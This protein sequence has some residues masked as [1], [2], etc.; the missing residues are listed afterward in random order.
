MTTLRNLGPRSASRGF[1]LVEILVGVAIG[2]VGML[3]IF[4]TIAVWDTHTRSTTAGSDSQNTGSLA[5][6][7]LE[8]DVKQA[9]HGFMGFG[10]T[11]VTPPASLGCQVNVADTGARTLPFAPFNMAPVEIVLTPGQPD[12]INVLSGNSPFFVSE[13]KFVGST[14]TSK[15]LERR[16]GF[17]PGDLAIAAVGPVCNLI[18][19][20]DDT[21]ADGRTID[22][23][24]AANYPSFYAAPAAPPR[25]AR[26]NSAALPALTQLGTLYS[27]GPNPIRNQWGVIGGNLTRT[28][29]FSGGPA[30]VVGEGVVNVK[31][32]YGLDTLGAIGTRTVTLWTNVAPVTP[33]GWAQV[34]SI[35]VA[36]LVRSRQF[37][38]SADQSASGVPT[39]VTLQAPTWSGA[40][41]IPPIPNSNFVM[42]NVGGGPD[43]FGPNDPDPNNWRYYRY[44][45]YEKEIPLR[46]VMWGTAP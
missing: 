23:A 46:N 36:L 43:S 26:Y 18:E 7:N 33:A 5:M 11:T 40:T 38:R 4:R 27:L 29:A 39:G 25:T 34:L 32:I 2:I 28:E 35:R 9:G 30:F 16:S 3:V 44:R 41:M 45:V 15:T 13:A 6:F 37:E 8:R 22:H 12:T 21:N 14:A 19:I 20:T 31:A 10:P 42:T 1:S 24:P 17:H